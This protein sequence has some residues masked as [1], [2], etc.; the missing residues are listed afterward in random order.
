VWAQ[1]DDDFSNNVLTDS[2]GCSSNFAA[3]TKSF[4]NNNISQSLYYWRLC[5]NECPQFDKNIYINGAKLLEAIIKQEKNQQVRDQ[6]LDTLFLVFEKRVEL[7]GEEGKV[8]GF[9]AEDI[10]KFRPEDEDL[11]YQMIQRSID[12]E[13]V[14][15]RGKVLSLNV[16]LTLNKVNS[17][18]LEQID[19]V[20]AYAQAADIIAFNL[21]EK[22]GDKFYLAAK[23]VIDDIYTKDIHLDCDGLSSLFS[24]KLEENASNVEFLKKV[25]S[26]LEM[27]NCTGDFY[28]QVVQSIATSDPSPEILVRMAEDFKARNEMTKAVECYKKAIAKEADKKKKAELYYALAEAT[29]DYPTLSIMYCNSAVDLRPNFARPYM[30]IAKQYAAGAYRCGKG[31]KYA[32]FLK[33]TMYWSAVDKLETAKSLDHALAEEANMLIAEY[34]KKFPTLEEITFQGLQIGSVYRIDCWIS[35]STTV[36]INNGQ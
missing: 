34:Q 36:R 22:P 6:F 11:A 21:V 24:T 9:K 19:L 12:L 4:D 18:M 25:K 26:L 28:N 27:R 10:I 15:S 33:K 30:L 7:Y 29:V 8:L 14:N 3:F 5:F 31:T 20:E 13:G 35:S 2:V 32:E 1:D 17:G 16:Q 23:K